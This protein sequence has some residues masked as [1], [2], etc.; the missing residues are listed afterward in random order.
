MTEQLAATPTMPPRLEWAYHAE[1][2]RWVDGDTVIL[3]IDAGFRMSL[4]DSF[5]LLGVDTPEKR[6]RRAD[7]GPAAAAQAFCEALAP[8]GSTVPVRTHRDRN[9]R[10]R[11]GKYGRYLVEIWPVGIGAGASINQRLII[12]GHARAYGGGKR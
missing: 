12:S 9:N 7:P 4:T 11:R 5:R 3:R 6:G 8:A 2:L 1:V 10:D